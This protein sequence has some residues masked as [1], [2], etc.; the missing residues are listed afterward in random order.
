MVFCGDLIITNN[1]GLQNVSFPAMTDVRGV[2]DIRV[3]SNLRCASRDALI[4]QVSV[5]GEMALD[6]GCVGVPAPCIPP[7]VPAQ[8]SVHSD[9]PTSCNA[10]LSPT[11]TAQA[12]LDALLN[13][14]TALYAPMTICLEAGTYTGFTS[15]SRFRTCGGGA[16]WLKG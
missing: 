14:G 7:T 16:V 5:W 9:F 4:A 2:F 10:T 1:A 8:L 6:T 3:N 11:A 15:G 12:E 13:S